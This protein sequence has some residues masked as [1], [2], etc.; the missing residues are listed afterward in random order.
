M[1]RIR[2]LFLSM[3]AVLAVGAVGATSASA[4]PCVAG[5]AGD[6]CFAVELGGILE[7]FSSRKDPGT[8]SA[9]AVQ[10]LGRITCEK[11]EDLGTFLEGEGP[12]VDLLVI[13]FSGACKLEQP[14]ESCEVA[15]PIETKPIMGTLLL[16][17]DINFAPETGTEFASVTIQG[18][19]CL[20]AAVLVV[21]G[22]QL[23]EDNNLNIDLLEHLIECL[24]SGSN[25]KASA[26]AATFEL[27]ESI[28]LEGP[29]AGDKW[30]WFHEML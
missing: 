18:N 28:A 30:G 11:A 21:K 13:K 16:T 10:G 1:M 4:S 12:H 27:D 29:N 8:A 6:W 7:V 22:T 19:P 9:L 15:E 17:N 24:T 20:P 5:G 26:K 3:F 14:L 23:C 2:L 25:L